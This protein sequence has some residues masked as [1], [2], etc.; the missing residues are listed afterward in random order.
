MAESAAAI[1]GVVLQVGEL[2]EIGTAFTK[3]AYTFIGRYGGTNQDYRDIN[4]EVFHLVG[5]LLTL[6]GFLESRNDAARGDR[7]S[8]LRDTIKTCW[9]LIGRLD[10]LLGVDTSHQ[11]GRGSFFQ[12]LEA[13]HQNQRP[14]PVWTDKLNWIAVK[15]EA[16]EILQQLK[17]QR[18]NII[19]FL[20]IGIAQGVQAM[21]IDVK[22]TNKIVHVVQAQMNDSEMREYKR[23]WTTIIDEIKAMH[24][25]KRSNQEPRTCKWI[26]LEQNWINWLGRASEDGTNIAPSS[27][28]CWIWGIPGSGKTVMASFLIDQVANDKGQRNCSYYYCLHSRG[29]D[30]TEDFLRCVVKDLQ[31]KV[32]HIPVILRQRFNE[33]AR[34]T[35]DDLLESLIH[36]AEKLKRVYIIVDA[37]DESRNREHIARVLYKIGTSNSFRR[38]SLLVASRNEADIR[39]IFT[40][41]S[42][43][44][45]EIPMS[46]AGVKDDMRRLAHSELV[47]FQDWSETMTAR[48]EN[49]LVDRAQ[50]MFRW[51]VCQL[52]LVKRLNQETFCD[53]A[54]ILREIR[55]FPEDLFGTYERILA[56]IKG[57]DREF[58][59]TALALLCNPRTPIPSAEILVE[60]SLYKIELGKIGKY[61]VELLRK[62][63]SCLVTVAKRRQTRQA[64]KFY[65]PEEQEHRAALAHYTVKEYLFSKHAAEGVASFFALSQEFLRIVDLMVFFRGLQ[66][67]GIRKQATEPRRKTQVH[68]YDEHA[69]VVTEHALSYRRLE[70]L[71][72]AEL[73]ELVLSSLKPSSQHFAYLKQQGGIRITM[74]NNFPQWDKLLFG[75]DMRPLGQNPDQVG[76]LLNL[77]LLG[78]PEMA[79]KYLEGFEFSSLGG[80]KKEAIWTEP[81][82]I[83]NEAYETLPAHVV[84]TRDRAFLHLFTTHGAFFDFESEVLFSILQSLYV[85]GDD[86]DETLSLLKEVLKHGADPNPRPTR[87]RRQ[88][89][90]SEERPL[91]KH[92]AFTPLQVAVACLE[93]EWVE[94]LLEA[95]ADPYDCGIK[96]GYVPRAFDSFVRENEDGAGE[97]LLRRGL[98]KPM[99]I[100][101][102][103][104]PPWSSGDDSDKVLNTAR[105]QVRQALAGWLRRGTDETDIRGG[106][107]YDPHVVS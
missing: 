42:P 65:Y 2:I 38:I 94:I 4:E 83:Q 100:C 29:K 87:Y 48:V 24:R 66:R 6:K 26:T 58:A 17:T 55:N 73:L 96:G 10:K 14:D 11:S 107:M 57:E 104:T 18:Q 80:K 81:F 90:E 54:Y 27:R 33:D 3:N 53:E 19:L 49:A 47:K 23:W 76:L 8:Q 60:A 88:S 40:G 30:E 78:W 85:L 71:D 68:P 92:F 12:D 37:I 28:F 5:D 45:V 32:E 89:P 36:L 75:I 59:R 91:P 82:R 74:R 93:S 103:T 39:E 20:Q 50:G 84:R 22:N 1:F 31:K 21:V 62:V 106:T 70:L 95:G 101:E 52:D 13:G 64:P 86:S 69:L 102:T 97:S 35:E 72:S 51:L 77:V 41:Q 67:F 99:D 63:C 7:L 43:P 16:L 25:E 61:N 98:K 34:P 79:K 9:E 46:G 105:R 56:Q 44:C 15:D